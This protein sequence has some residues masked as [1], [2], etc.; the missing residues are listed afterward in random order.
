[1]K[2][3]PF[4]LSVK[5]LI[6][7]SEGRYL[8]I[9]RSAKSKNNAGKW[10]FPGGKVDA[11]E[12]FD[13]ALIREVEEEAGL[14]I[15]LLRLAGSAQSDMADRVVVYLIMEAAVFGGKFNISDEHDEHRWVSVD[16][17]K[18]LDVCGQFNNFVT[19]FNPQ[20]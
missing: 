2:D 5:V 17:L 1:M 10:D 16:E 12:R 3:K 6:R 20:A 4:V 7:D 13:A 15:N 11:G 14:K 9:R 19:G 18:G 8:V